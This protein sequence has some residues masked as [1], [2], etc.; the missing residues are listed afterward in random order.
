MS[1]SNA[2]L[3]G[4]LA[5]VVLTPLLVAGW[6]KADPPDWSLSVE[7]SPAAVKSCKAI[8]R[9]SIAAIVG[10]F[11][12][13][14][15]DWGWT[16]PLHIVGAVVAI[17][18]ILAIPYL[19][20]VFRCTLAGAE[21]TKEYVAYYQSKHEVGIRAASFIGIVST[22]VLLASLVLHELWLR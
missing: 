16:A 2:I 22:Y 6:R 8:E 14:G 12:L 4:F 1:E 15:L 7:L 9:E 10:F 5:S 17:A 19:W 18:G 11:I 20:T 21:R 13:L 3:V